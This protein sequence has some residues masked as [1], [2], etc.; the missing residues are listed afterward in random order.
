MASAVVWA[1]MARRLWVALRGRAEE[2]EEEAAM[3]P[4]K[5][6][7]GKRREETGERNRGEKQS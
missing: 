6:R 2:E 5:L 7:P 1:A 3:D 4:S